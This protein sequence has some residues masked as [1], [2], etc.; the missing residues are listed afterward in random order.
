MATTHMNY[1][2]CR[3]PEV[4]PYSL[5]LLTLYVLENTERAVLAVTSFLMCCQ[6]TNLSI[7]HYTGSFFVIFALELIH[8]ALYSGLMFEPLQLTPSLSPSL[9]SNAVNMTIKHHISHCHFQFP[10]LPFFLLAISLLH[11]NRRVRNL[12]NR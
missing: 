1:L 11:F 4:Y 5:L 8:S 6:N 2:L 12:K 3:S 10:N 7:S 9:V